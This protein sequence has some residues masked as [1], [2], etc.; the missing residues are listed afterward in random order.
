MCR[1]PLTEKR[2]GKLKDELWKMLL[3]QRLR[4]KS[5]GWM[6][7]YFPILKHTHTHTLLTHSICHRQWGTFQIHCCSHTDSNTTT[8]SIY[9]TLHTW[10]MGRN[11]PYIKHWLQ[12][13]IYILYVFLRNQ[14]DVGIDFIP[15]VVTNLL[16]GCSKQNYF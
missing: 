7:P 9:L 4:R 16:S 11:A 3:Y 15:V 8:S 12:I 13:A 2:E 10:M 1:L 5:I 14:L 6:F